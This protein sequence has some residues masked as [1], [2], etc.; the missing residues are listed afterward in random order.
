[1]LVSAAYSSFL[2]TSESRPREPMTIYTVHIKTSAVYGF[3]LPPLDDND[4]YPT[5]AAPI[6]NSTL[7]L[8]RRDPITIP[9]YAAGSII[10]IVGTTSSPSQRPSSASPSASA[11]RSISPPSEF[12]SSSPSSPG[13]S[14]LACID[15]NHR[16]SCQQQLENRVHLPG[17]PLRVIAFP[18]PSSSFSAPVDPARE[19]KGPRVALNL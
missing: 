7:H 8:L 2:A 16:P 12:T 19:P 3:F 1:M 18:F 17:R 4:D 13:L 9:G 5:A 6:T 15:T 11:S 10:T 14:A